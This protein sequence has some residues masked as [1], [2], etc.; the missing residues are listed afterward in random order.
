MVI[1]VSERFR[2]MAASVQRGGVEMWE[3][4]FARGAGGKRM[5]G[6]Q[7]AGCRREGKVHL[8]CWVDRSKPMYRS[9]LAAFAMAAAGALALLQ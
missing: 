5:S 8:H 6:A 2:W 4:R 1:H 7:C 9:P 3:V